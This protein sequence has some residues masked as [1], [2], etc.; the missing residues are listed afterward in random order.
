MTAI[1]DLT[2]QR[3]GRLTVI[4]ATD[5]RYRRN[6]V[7]EC[8]CNCGNTC[9][10]MSR[11]LLSGHVTS[12]GCRQRE[13]QTP[14]THGESGSRLHHIWCNMKYRCNTPSSKDFADYG[15]RGIS[16]CA[17]WQTDFAAF[18]EWALANGYQEGLSIDR[19]DVNG[20]YTPENCRWI[21]SSAQHSNT[22]SN[23]YAE[24]N[25]ERHT[26]AEWCRILNLPHNAV[27][28]RISRGMSP[29]KA[30][31]EPIR[32]RGRNRKDRP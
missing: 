16:V 3:F 17:E 5:Q 19:I 8:L 4:R 23:I 18:R 26:V 24:I 2:G 9:F 10:V 32:K 20:N 6:V 1:R 25:G 14:K 11:D 31:T 21:P 27:R 28:S 30:L 29:E 7:N 22:R 13:T 12:C 15:G